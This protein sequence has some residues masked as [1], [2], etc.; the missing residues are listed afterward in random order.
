MYIFLEKAIFTLFNFLFFF[1]PLIFYP[2]TSELFEFNKMVLVYIITVLIILA[3]VL[4]IIAEKKFTVRRTILDIPLLIFLGSQLLST[5]FSFD[6]RTSFLG[7]YSRFNGG[8]VSTF[9]F[10]LLFFAYTSNMNRRK[11]YFSLKTLMF[12]GFL[13]SLYGILEH[14]GIDKDLWVQDVQNRVFSTLGQPN[15]LAAFL[16]TLLPISWLFFL[17]EKKGLLWLFF[18]SVFFVTLL[19]T[20]SR[21]GLLG[22]AVADSFFVISV[23][24]INQKEKLFKNKILLLRL[25]L[26]NLIFIIF[27]LLLGTPFSPK[28]SDL[29]G[30]KGT[31]ANVP[32]VGPALETGG[33]ESGEIRKIVW[34]GAFQ[35]FK[36][37]PV[38]G[39]GVETFAFSYYNFKPVRHNL[40]SEWDFLYNKAHNEYLNFMANTGFVGLAS[41]LLLI[42]VFL[43]FVLQKIIAGKKEENDKL[44]MAALST[45]YLSILVTNFFGFSVVLISL[46]TFLIPAF[47][48]SLLNVEG[49]NKTKEI[50]L[51][52]KQK[53]LFILSVLFSLFLLF[54]ITRYW[55]ADTLYALGK[56]QNDTDNPIEAR[57]NLVKAIKLSSRESI[58]WMELA[59]ADTTI[60]TTLAEDKDQAKEVASFAV[61]EAIRATTLSPKNPNLERALAN[62]YI[63]LSGLDE[64]YLFKA[65]DAILRTLKL[66]PTDAKLMY[67][68]GLITARVGK[69]DEAINTFRKTI[70]MKENYREPRYALALLLIDKGQTKE[71][72][73]QLNFILEKIS[74]KDE[75]SIKL[76]KSLK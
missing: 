12:S 74:P 70:I 24:F 63:R 5:V 23:F 10:T 30:K 15:W 73:E 29:I 14:F 31:A 17:K 61:S 51:S 72:K 3:W 57:K 50:S 26:V 21:S 47:L 32:V 33:T 43:K 52:G 67:N 71:A 39:T 75:A 66:A 16:V 34:E 36:H 58:F 38:F 6:P 25:G 45:G 48:F 19:F 40:V 42:I 4:K 76:L 49:G 37:Y 56:G 28:L 11:S 35:I 65:K 54:S 64:R 53:I 59:E 41:Y 9:S 62:I 7:Y 46:L 44:T 60:A 1:V 20:K 2:S 18:S 22:L 55:Y 8:F 69:N 27:V 13:V 68:L